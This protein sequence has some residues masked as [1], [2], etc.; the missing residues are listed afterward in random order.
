MERCVQ[1][2]K[3]NGEDRERE[4]DRWEK[5]KKSVIL[6]C[7]YEMTGKHREDSLFP[8]AA[9]FRGRTEGDGVVEV[10]VEPDSNGIQAAITVDFQTDLFLTTSQ[11]LIQGLQM[12][13]GYSNSNQGNDTSTITKGFKMIIIL[14]SIP[15][16][17]CPWNNNCHNTHQPKLYIRMSA[18]CCRKKINVYNN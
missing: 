8:A 9:C 10:E 13:E 7:G 12:T 17:G 6:T 14:S 11:T 18:F 4:G 2:R 3:C 5:G 16:V 15:V 1:Q